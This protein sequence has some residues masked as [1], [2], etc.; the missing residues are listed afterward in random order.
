MSL[1]SHLLLY[2]CTTNTPVNMVNETEG[3]LL[4]GTK[5]MEE[6]SPAEN[7]HSLAI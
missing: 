4:S 6:L 3:S 5:W 7:L 2:G 1:R